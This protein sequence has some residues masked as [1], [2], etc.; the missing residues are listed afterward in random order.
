M[1][2]N[3]IYD[4]QSAQMSDL[5]ATKQAAPILT[6]EGLQYNQIPLDSPNIL[7]LP[8]E[9]SVQTNPYIQF[10]DIEGL[11]G[12]KGTEADLFPIFDPAQTVV[13]LPDAPNLPGS[14]FTPLDDIMTGE[15]PASGGVNVDQF[16]PDKLEKE[17]ATIQ[18][19]NTNTTTNTSFPGGGGGGTF[20]PPQSETETTETET[21]ISPL[22]Y[23]FVGVLGLVLII[24]SFRK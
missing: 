4:E 11:V 7:P 6:N 13:Y 8:P 14:G 22:T 10:S 9:K 19:T 3:F 23:V 16:S 1:K 20:T 2:K 18:P 17:T 5:Y 21:K 12:V 24:F 15:G